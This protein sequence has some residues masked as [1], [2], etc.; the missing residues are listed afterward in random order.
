MK[1]A[2]DE[3]PTEVTARLMARIGELLAE[4]QDRYPQQPANDADR[5]WVPAH[6]GG[7]APTF[8]EAEARLATERT[9]KEA[10]RR[11]QS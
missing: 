7:T 9:E 6:R 8:D 2:H 11:A 10:R 1:F 4:A 3:D 5:W